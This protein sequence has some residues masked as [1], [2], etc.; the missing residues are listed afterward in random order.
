MIMAASQ[1][2]WHTARAAGIVAWALSALAVL[3]GRPC[4]PVRSATDPGPGRAASARAR[5]AAPSDRTRRAAG[6][7]RSGSRSGQRPPLEA[8]GH[9]GP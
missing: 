5:K 8:A 1:V 2:W 9:V 7:S 6:P 3:W 4:R